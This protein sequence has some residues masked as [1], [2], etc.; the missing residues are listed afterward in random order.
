MPAQQL[1]AAAAMLLDWL[2]VCIRHDWLQ[3]KTLKPLGEDEVVQ[4]TPG[5]GNWDAHMRERESMGLHLPYGPAAFAAGLAVDDS[6]P[7]QRAGP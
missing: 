2:K 3:S 7:S 6:I 5:R 1:R 4:R